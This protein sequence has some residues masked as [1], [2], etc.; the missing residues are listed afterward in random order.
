MFLLRYALNLVGRIFWNFLMFYK[1][2][3]WFPSLRRKILLRV[4]G[5]FWNLLRR[6]SLLD[7][8]GTFWNLLGT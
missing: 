3:Q 8:G 2:P 7:V 5:T 4:G 1:D 6:K